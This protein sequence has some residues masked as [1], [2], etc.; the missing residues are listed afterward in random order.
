MSGYSAAAGGASEPGEP[1]SGPERAA[2]W[3]A[4]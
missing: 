1:G 4:A 2:E 3:L